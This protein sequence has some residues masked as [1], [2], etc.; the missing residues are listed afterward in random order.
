[1]ARAAARFNSSARQHGY[2]DTLDPRIHELALA[3]SQHRRRYRKAGIAADL[4]R[5]LC[6]GARILARVRARAGRLAGVAVVGAVV[7]RRLHLR[8][9]AARLL[10]RCEDVGRG[11]ACGVGRIGLRPLRDVSDAGIVQLSVQD[12]VRGVAQATRVTLHFQN[13]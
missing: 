6:R 3:C 2:V 4:R 7:E 11:H 13:Q 5:V 8:P 1:M 9:V 10:G 12:R